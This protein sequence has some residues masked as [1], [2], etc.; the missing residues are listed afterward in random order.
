MRLQLEVEAGGVGADLAVGGEL[1]PGAAPEPVALVGE[2][3]HRS[4]HTAGH[5]SLANPLGL[6]LEQVCEVG[7]VAQLD[8]DRR[9]VSAWFST[10]MSSWI[11]SDTI[12]SR[13]IVIVGFSPTRPPS[14]TPTTR[15]E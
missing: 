8:G 12:R 9:A 2:R 10:E 3:H 11:P 7:G 4:V 14:A 6:D 5:G 13:W 1:Q 15:A